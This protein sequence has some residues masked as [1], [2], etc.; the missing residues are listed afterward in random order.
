MSRQPPAYGW[1]LFWRSLAGLVFICAPGA[2]IT[3]CLACS[4]A[5][6]HCVWLP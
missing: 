3:L 6:Q 2:Y 1:P 5:V 4:L